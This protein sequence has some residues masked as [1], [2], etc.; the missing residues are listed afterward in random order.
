MPAHSQ[1]SIRVPHLLFVLVIPYFYE[2][3]MKDIHT[4][5]DE[6][7]QSNAPNIIFKVKFNSILLFIKINNVKELRKVLTNNSSAG[8]IKG[9][10]FLD[11][12]LVFQT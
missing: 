10:Q 3:G 1:F 4:K 11:N 12:L 9:Q 7:R 5:C 8:K 2:K 6:I